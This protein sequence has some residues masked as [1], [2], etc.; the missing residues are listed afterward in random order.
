MGTSTSLF[1]LDN[2]IFYYHDN[3][4]LIGVATTHVDDVVWAGTNYFKN[5]VIK[6]VKETFKISRESQLHF[7]YLGLCLE[8]NE[9]CIL[10]HQ[11]EYSDQLKCIEIANRKNRKATDEITEQEKGQLRSRIGQLNWLSTQTR[12][13]I[14]YEVCQASVNFK[15]AILK[16][17]ENINKVIKK[18]KYEDVTLNIRIYQIYQKDHSLFT[19][20]FQEKKKKYQ[21]R[22]DLVRLEHMISNN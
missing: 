22:N 15:R 7:V 18:L 3:G 2:A 4:R 21:K 1:R 19:Y 9:I 13:D 10:L 14:S 5:K 8:Q 11:K 16:D 12:P 6:A 17:L 20:C